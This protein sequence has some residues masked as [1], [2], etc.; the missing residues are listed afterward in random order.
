MMV[1]H[2]NGTIRT[3][4]VL[5]IAAVAVPLLLLTAGAWYDRSLVLHRAER[6][7]AKILTLF[8]EQAENLFRGHDILL[9]LVIGRAQKF[10]WSAIEASPDLL[11]DLEAIDRRMDDASG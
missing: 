11:D 8:Q 4:R 9:D 6:D 7:A 10:D 1:Q 3:L 2:L 5:I